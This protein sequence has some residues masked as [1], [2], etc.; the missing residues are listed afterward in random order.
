M[1]P[2]VASTHMKEKPRE[3]QGETWRQPQ[4][5]ISSS[6]QLIEQANKDIKHLNNAQPTWPDLGPS[7]RWPR[8]HPPNYKII[9]NTRHC[10]WDRVEDFKMGKLS[11]IAGVGP[12]WSGGLIRRSQSR[13]PKKRDLRMARRELRGWRNGTQAR[14]S[15]PSLEAGRWG[16]RFCPTAFRGM[17]PSQLIL[18]FWPL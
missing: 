5:S 13:R 17:Q 4:I 3:L 6:Q 9:E 12:M 7:Q 1:H 16:D 14:G 11:Q 2:G 10:R 8:P 15:R 18:D